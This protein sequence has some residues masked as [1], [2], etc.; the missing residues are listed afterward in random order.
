[1][2][3]RIQS[4]WLFLACICGFLLYMFPFFVGTQG[5]D[6]AMKELSATNNIGTTISNTIVIVLLIITILL[7]KNRKLQL[8]LCIVAV[9]A[10]AIN[11]ALG[12]FATKNY[13][14]GQYTI[15]ALLFIFVLFFIFLAASAI[16]KDEK[17]VR[18]SDRLR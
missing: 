3:Q 4:V 5:P 13:N 7:F 11:F 10:Q 9:I 17:M 14:S 18:N 2:I 1:M 15:W 16:N 12:H 6:I 8:R